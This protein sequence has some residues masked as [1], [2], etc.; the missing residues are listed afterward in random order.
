MLKNRHVKRAVY[1]YD[2]NKNFINKYDGVTDAQRALNIGQATI[3]KYA[4][5]RAVYKDYIFS[6]DRIN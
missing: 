1:V 3:K 4:E 6:F 2:K 5:V